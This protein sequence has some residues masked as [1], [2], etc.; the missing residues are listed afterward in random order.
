MLLCLLGLAWSFGFASGAGWAFAG[1]GDSDLSA[2]RPRGT[3]LSRAQEWGHCVRVLSFDEAGMTAAFRHLAGGGLH[4]L[5]PA[6]DWS[7]SWTSH[8]ASANAAPCAQCPTTCPDRSM[9]AVIEWLLGA[10]CGFAGASLRKRYR[11]SQLRL[12]TSPSKALSNLLLSLSPERFETP[13]K[14]RLQ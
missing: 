14:P 4:G 1:L 13:R 6:V 9:W 2:N 3:L 5:L 12:D 8:S 11:H 10:G 7:S